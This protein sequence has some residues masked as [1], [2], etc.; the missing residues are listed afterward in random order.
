MSSLSPQAQ[1]KLREMHLRTAKRWGAEPGQQFSATPSVAQ[2][3]N[4]KI[5]QDGDPFLKL[6]NT[7]GVKQL[8]G[9][10]VFLGVDGT[11]S[12]RTDTNVPGVERAAR[13]LASLDDS[14][15]QLHKTD[16]DVAL[17]YDQIDNW[18][19]FPDFANMYGSAVRKAI[20][21][22]R[23]RIGWYGTQAVATTNR[24]AHPNLEDVNIGWLEQVRT[25]KAGQQYLAGTVAAPIVLGGA[26]H[27]NLDVLVHEARA[28][29]D[30][31]FRGSTD[32]VALVSGNL[33]SYEEGA[34]YK[35]HGR[36]PTEKI[37]MLNDVVTTKYGGL[38]CITPPFMPDGVLFIT[39]L[40]N[41]SIY[42]QTTSWRRQQI[43]NPK[44]DQYEDFNTRNEGY[45]IEEFLKTALVDGITLAPAA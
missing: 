32:L 42:W 10:K 39:S 23:L 31:V 20:A 34:Y 3:L 22:D 43:D 19:E 13:R 7:I 27:P 26:T 28:M 1:A 35:E 2:S 36:R 11:V 17:G 21:N 14:Q 37:A 6:V 44:K 38:P 24:T 45:V 4:E 41:L 9:K 29:V 40:K 30:I 5:V 15:Y 8:I 16:S 25:W 33:I 18:A 12:G